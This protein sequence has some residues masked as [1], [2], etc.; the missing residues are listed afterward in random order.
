MATNAGPLQ[1][2][3]TPT[4]VL[5]AK[6]PL[7]RIDGRNCGALS[8]PPCCCRSIRGNHPGQE[9]E[10][11]ANGIVARRRIKKPPVTTSALSHQGLG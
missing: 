6:F 2:L 4:L 1:P 8:F 10:Q 3:A 11:Y 9:S 7:I 5:E